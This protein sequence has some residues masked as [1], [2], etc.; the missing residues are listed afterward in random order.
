MKTHIDSELTTRTRRALPVVAAGAVLL[1]GGA[2]AYA[3]TSETPSDSVVGLALASLR[4]AVAALQAQVRTLQAA[5][6]I[7]RATLSPSGA[8]LAQN[9]GWLAHVEHPFAG[10]YG[11]TFARGAF[12]APPTCVA[13]AVGREPAVPAAAS[14]QVLVGAAVS[15]SPAT[16]SSMTCQGWAEHTVAV[17]TGISLICVGP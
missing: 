7:D 15:C 12:S 2:A 9:G 14:G 13:T 1:F 3:Q 17:D 10:T 4:S 6:H 8:V 16:P 5:D 11:L